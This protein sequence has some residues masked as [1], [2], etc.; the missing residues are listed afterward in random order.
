[1]VKISKEDIRYLAFEGGGGKGIAYIGALQALEELEILSYTKKEVNRQSSVKLNS[2]KIRGVS[3]TSAGSMSALLVACGYTPEELR[4]IFSQNIGKNV[5]DNVEFGKMPTIYT[6]K[7]TDIIVQDPRFKNVDKYIKSSWSNYLKSEDKNIKNLL[8]LP[9]NFFKRSSLQF[10]SFLLRGYL[11]YEARKTKKKHF[12]NSANSLIKELVKS[13][14]ISPALTHVL[15]EP[16]H[17]F[18]S[19][20]YEYGLFLGETLRNMF[21]D[22]IEKKSG[23]KN[24]TFE[25]FVKEFKIDLV[26]TSVCINTKEVFYFRNNEKWKDLCVA[27]AVRMSVGIP[28]LFKPVLLKQTEKEIHSITKDFNSV[29][30]MVDGGMINNFPIH[31]FDECDSEKLKNSIVG[32]RLKPSKR[33]SYTEISSLLEYVDNIQ[34]ILLNNATELQISQPSDNEQVI[35]LNSGNISI[36]DFAFDELPEEIISESKAKTLKYFE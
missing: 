7:N 24:C 21:D 30:L 20:K 13:E 33:Q 34:Y 29:N 5:L 32:F 10:F 17:S 16:L 8:G 23:I 11:S 12:D 6:K 28:F 14:T 26:I 18:N 3:G 9:K 4:D 2:N 15:K 19:L 22:W 35:E 25:M 1:M 36:F 27:D 31:S